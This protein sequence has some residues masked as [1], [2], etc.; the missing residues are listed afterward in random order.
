MRI[1]F[2]YG[3]KMADTDTDNFMKVNIRIRIR[4]YPD[5]KLLPTNFNFTAPNRSC[6]ILFHIYF[7]LS[8]DIND[9]TICFSI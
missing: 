2:A 4:N 7:S 1:I 3:E 5:P 8:C 6:Y 9:N